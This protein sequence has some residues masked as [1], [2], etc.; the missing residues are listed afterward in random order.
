MGGEGNATQVDTLFPLSCRFK[1]IA[2][3][4]ETMSKKKSAGAKTKAAA[5]DESAVTRQM[6]LASYGKL[7]KCVTFMP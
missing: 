2:R 7:C 1:V 5:V 3:A 4:G 6:V